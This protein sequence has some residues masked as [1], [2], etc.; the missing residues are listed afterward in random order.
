VKKR[1][2][3]TASTS[4]AA[5][6]FVEAYVQAIQDRNAA[7]FAGAGLSI[8]AGMVNWKGLLSDIG[9]EIGLDVKK[10]DD[11]ITL[12][13]YH[14]NERGRHRINEKLLNEF[15]RRARLTESHR[16]LAS[17]P[18]RTYWTTNY[19]GLIEQAVRDQRKRP[20]VKFTIE[21]LATT[22]YD[23]D[24][25]VYKM[26]GDVSLPDKAVV[27]KDDYEAYNS[28]HQLFSSALQGDLISKTFLFIGFSFTDPNLAYILSRIVCFWTRTRGLTTRSCGES[29][30]RTLTPLLPTA[31]PWGSRTC[32]SATCGATG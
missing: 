30:A 16:V 26:H 6:T 4:A 9:R 24:A 12:A 1:K 5:S 14:V 2:T 8:P 20:D 19:D 17:L 10:E 13:Q 7:V 31:T 15:S 23:R 32:K 27:T 18:I 3:S 25:V 29:S 11:L 28:T 21:S 22:L